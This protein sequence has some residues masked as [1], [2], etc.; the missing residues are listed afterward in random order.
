MRAATPFR[1][2]LPRSARRLAA[3]L[4]L[5][6]LFGTVAC[7]PPPAPPPAPV[8]ASE[9]VSAG[10]PGSDLCYLTVAEAV[11]NPHLDADQVPV[12]LKMVPP[13]FKPPY[14]RGVFGKGNAMRLESEVIVDTLGK[15]D[16]STFTVVSV[17]HPWFATQAK[18]A[19][20]KWSFTPA[21]KTGCKVLRVYKLGISLG[22]RAVK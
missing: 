9:P 7:A 22:P 8:P 15:A 2:G 20:A 19:V 12:P 21:A 17:S 10:A 11:K 13:V 18:K 1:R 4:S 16:M 3:R 5:A 6:S 14:P